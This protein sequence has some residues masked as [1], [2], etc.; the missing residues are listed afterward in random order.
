MD[1]VVTFPGNKKVKAS[2]R[3]FEILSDQRKESGGDASAPE[4]F[5]LFLASI[6]NCGATY[7]IYFCEKRG[8]PLDGIR[9]VQKMERDSETRMIKKI[10]MEVEL[11]EDFPEKYKKPLLKAIDLCAV[12]RHILDPPE[13]ELYTTT[14]PE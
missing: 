5:M 12:K 7:I 9:F 3:G 13:F 11:P 6:A 10:K 14:A 8:I 1:M 2:Y 4:P